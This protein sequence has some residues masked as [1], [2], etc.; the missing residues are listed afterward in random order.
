MMSLLRKSALIGIGLA[1]MTR[2]KIEETARKIAKEDNLSEEEGRRLAEELLQQADEA[3]ENF[4]AQVEKLVRSAME[5]MDI[6]T[7][8]Q[9]R[10]LDDR[11]KKLEDLVAKSDN[12]AP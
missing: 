10:E 3:G 7:G 4:K 1:Y 9:F 6:C 2:D 5:R 12:S 8:K 11:V